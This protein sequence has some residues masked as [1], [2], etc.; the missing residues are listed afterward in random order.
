MEVKKAVQVAKEHVLDLF[1]EER[2]ANLGLEEVE[3]DV[4]SKEWVVILGFSRPWDEPRNTL[5]VLAQTALP[6]R[7]YKA[8]RISDF[9]ERVKSVKVYEPKT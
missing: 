2:V 6:R 4:G 5:A 9:D 1:A 3:F 8:V 7:I